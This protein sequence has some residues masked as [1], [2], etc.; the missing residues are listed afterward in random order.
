[1]NNNELPHRCTEVSNILESECIYRM[2][3]PAYFPDLNSIE[4][5]LDA[6]GRCVSKKNLPSLPNRERVENRLER[7][8][9]QYPQG[10]LDS[11]I[12]SMNNRYKMCVSV[13]K[14]RK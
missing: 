6:L 8:I 3:Y 13:Q 10:L 12:Y 1:M 5:A 7:G 2:Q 11:L 14:N 4:H 9:G